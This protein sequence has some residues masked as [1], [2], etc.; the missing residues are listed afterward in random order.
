MVRVFVDT[1]VLVRYFIAD[2]EEK[3]AETLGLVGKILTGAVVPYISTI[4]LLELHYVLKSV[5][6]LPQTRCIEVLE[7][8]TGL[9]NC[10]LVEKTDFREAISFVKLYKVKLPDCMIATQIPKGVTFVSYD[11]EFKKIKVLKMSAVG[12]FAV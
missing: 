3:F 11:Q 9:R 7:I 1:S 2:D 8:V 10:V 4:V 6:K 5:Y 12:E